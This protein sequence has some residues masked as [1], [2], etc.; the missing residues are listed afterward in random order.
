MYALGSVRFNLTLDNETSSAD[1][2]GLHN[3]YV[4][5]LAVVGKKA[6]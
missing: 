3:E 5:K 4:M 6:T 1:A 2:F